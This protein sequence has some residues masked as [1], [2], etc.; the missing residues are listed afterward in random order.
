MIL[1]KKHLLRVQIGLLFGLLIFGVNL[2]KFNLVGSLYLFD[3]LLII[4]GLLSVFFLKTILPHK[5][6]LFISSLSLFYLAYSFS[7]DTRLDLIIRQY[8]LFG[9]LI[10]SYIVFSSLLDR[11]NIDF[12]INKIIQMSIIGFVI[13]IVFFIYLNIAGKFNFSGYNYWSPVVIM[14]IIT[15]AAYAITYFKRLKIWILFLLTAFLSTT[16]GHSSA[17]LAVFILPFALLFARVALVFKI[18][19]ILFGLFTGLLL[20]LF[21]PSFSDPNAMWRV[22]YWFMT[23]KNILIDHF[24]LFGNGFGVPY[25]TEEIAYFLQVEQGATTTLGKGDESYLSPFHNSFIT[26]FF[27]IGLIPGLLIFYPFYK[28]MKNYKILIQYKETKFLFLALI[29]ISVWS[30]FNVILELPHSS[31]YYWTIYFALLFK[32]KEVLSR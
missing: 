16:L 6:I 22:Y 12:L 17:F 7:F 10:I 13:Q 27:H 3:L 15:Y 2:S 19:V 8:A 1:A 25:A 11:N 24:A 14:A 28:F 29:G 30:S 9:Y 31:L 23:F 20:F 21:V 5:P 32:M 4:L 26:I 18:F